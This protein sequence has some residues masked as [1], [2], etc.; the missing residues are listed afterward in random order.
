MT[1]LDPERAIL[2]IVV[3]GF[4]HQ[5]G[6]EVEFLY[7]PLGKQRNSQ[8]LILPS[9]WR[10]LPFLA[11]PDG[12]HNCEQDT[13]SSIYQVSA[14]QTSGRTHNQLFLGFLVIGR[15]IVRT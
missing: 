11:L 8:S 4:H 6:S 13:L 9:E 1:D 3:V 7:P 10:F 14:R 5:R 15:L 12:A 2:H